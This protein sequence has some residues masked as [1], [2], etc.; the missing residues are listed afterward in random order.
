MN[1]DQ[2]KRIVE[3]AQIE[4]ENVSNPNLKNLDYICKQLLHCFH[5]S[6][7]QIQDDSVGPTRLNWST[8]Y[9]RLVNK[10]YGGLCYERDEILFQFLKF[11]GYEPHR[12]EARAVKADGELANR[13][14]HMAVAVRI[15]EQW[16]LCDCGWGGICWNGA[17]LLQPM[18]ETTTDHLII[19]CNP[20][21]NSSNSTLEKS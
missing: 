15:K 20:E 3:L 9:D 4:T 1:S 7:L 8:V 21:T 11:I 6:T 12:I 2:F 19:R 18:T 10:R 16:Y 14:D 5:Y 17:I 13:H